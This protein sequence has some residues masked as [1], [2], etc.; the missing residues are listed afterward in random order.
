MISRSPIFT[1]AWNTSP[2]ED[3]EDRPGNN[4]CLSADGLFKYRDRHVELEA[5]LP[6][7][8]TQRY[9]EGTEQAKGASFVLLFGACLWKERPNSWL[10]AADLKQCLDVHRSRGALPLKDLDGNFCLI[11]YDHLSKSVWVASDFWA[12]VGFYY[13]SSKNLTVVSS[14]AAEVADRIH[15]PIDAAA[16]LCL[17]RSTVPAPGSSLFGGVSRITMGQALRLTPF[18]ANPR[19][20]ATAPLYE[21]LEDWS[22]R[23]SVDRTR[24]SLQRTVPDCVSRE[25]TVVDLTAGNDTR[26]IAAALAP[27]ADITA[28]LTF[29]VT[30]L[31]D[32][33]D[34]EIAT[35][36]AKHFSWHHIA[37]MPVAGGLTAKSA[38]DMALAADGSF[39]IEFV[40]NR[41]LLETTRWPGARHLVGGSSG[42]LFR[43]WIWQQELHRMGG[44]A[45]NYTALLRHRVP[46]DYTVDVSVLT[47]GRLDNETHDQWLLEPLRQLDAQYPSALNV[48]KL[49]IYYIQRLMHRV[50]WWTIA[51]QLVTIL[52]F[53]WKSVTDVSLRMPWRH[54]RTR[55][56]VTTVVEQLDPWIAKVPTDRGAPF[57]PFRSGT[58]VD[59]IR[60]FSGYSSDIIRRHYLR[61]NPA[62]LLSGPRQ[63]S[64]PADHA[65]PA[66]LAEW[67]P[68]GESLLNDADGLADEVK[69]GNGQRLTGSRRAEFLTRL[70]VELLCR[71]YRGI[72]RELIFP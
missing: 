21:E 19:P 16:Y 32:S 36:I 7:W 20:V 57:Q 62:P 12:T 3:R 8:S 13:G 45:I 35:L 18:A 44:T 2:D 25:H 49:D 59:Y 67:L 17:L 37:H 65:L 54:K 43:S 63:S 10:S 68:A 53:L 55:R 50:P 69:Q 11:S 39:C 46:R 30:G 27:R 61:R 1:L 23:E 6:S 40:A 14:R 9:V 58:A 15:A 64:A 70:Q 28:P 42:E 22:F 24:V 47:R 71:H 31:P 38:S 4:T 66:E 34:V 29:G 52:P 33:P 56:L 41:L 48:S 51:S 72:R 5:V 60:Y 26:L